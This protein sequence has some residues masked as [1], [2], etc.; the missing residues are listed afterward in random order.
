MLS[1][2]AKG[3]K[4]Q[5]V[6]CNLGDKAQWH[7]DFNGGLVPILESPDGTM[8]N[9]SA[10]I[11]QFAVEYA[12]AEDGLKLWPSEGKTQDIAACMLTGKHKLLMLEFDKF[13]GA[14]WGAY[15]SRFT[16]DEKI[17]TMIESNVKLEAWFKKN[18][19]NGKFLNGTD[20]PSQLDIHCFVVVERLVHFEKTAYEGAKKMEVQKNCPIICAYV[21]RFCSH[22]LMKDQ[23]ITVDAF[24]KQ[25][26]LQFDMPMGEKYQLDLKSLN[27]ES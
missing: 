20:E 1:L 10:I 22:P 21:E 26:K 12:K 5:K 9:E 19:G 25:N 18:I 8:V 3:I 17:N 23:C 15:V 7:K 11:S 4:F 6:H 2:A 24:Q 14:F 13:M 27:Q 16:D